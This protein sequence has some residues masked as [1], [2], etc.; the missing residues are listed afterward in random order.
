M[1]M[2]DELKKLAFLA[3]DIKDAGCIATI[4]RLAASAHI[5]N[6]I[7]LKQLVEVIDMLTGGA[8]DE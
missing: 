1:S 7:T 4:G 2:F 8:A 5:K 3:A 6:E